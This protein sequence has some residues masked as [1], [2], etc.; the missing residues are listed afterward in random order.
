MSMH[1]KRCRTLI[2]RALCLAGFAVLAIDPASVEA[3]DTV[4]S[5]SAD[6]SAVENQAGST[7]DG[8]EARWSGSITPRLFLFDYFDESRENATPYVERYD[9]QKSIS[10]D[11]RS[12]SYPDVDVDLTYGDDRR[13]LFILERRGF[14][15][16]N[17]RGTALY[18]DD[19]FSA[20][21]SYRRYRSI[22]G[23]IDFQS[24]FGARGG[25]Q[26]PPNGP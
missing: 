23:A 1:K 12:G 6:E 25:P 11:T 9:V 14:G 26:G 16:Y 5:A 20:S 8:V 10:G 13:D 2:F 7:S 3:D 22:P 21:A 4:R 17:H 15:Q 24:M 18:S 19:G